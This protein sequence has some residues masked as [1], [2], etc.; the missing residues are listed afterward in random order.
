MNTTDT[1]NLILAE[2]K[3][4][5]GQPLTWENLQWLGFHIGAIRE[6]A[7]PSDLKDAV[8]QKLGGE[9]EDCR[10]ILIRRSVDEHDALVERAGDLY[11]IS[12][13]DEEERTLGYRLC[14][15]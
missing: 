4:L 7:T 3:T 5:K 6:V 8:L 10:E 13:E 2:L 1:L 15:R 11:F 9:Y 14:R 12:V